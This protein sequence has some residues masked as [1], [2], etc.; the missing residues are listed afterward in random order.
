M[1]DTFFEEA[2]FPAERQFSDHIEGYGEQNQY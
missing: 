2:E 1:G